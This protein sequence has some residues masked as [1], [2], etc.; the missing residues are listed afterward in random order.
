MTLQINLERVKNDLYTV[1]R[2]GYN[3]DDQG[4]YRQG[5]SDE[6]IKARAWF[7]KKLADLEL[8]NYMDGAGNVIG[9]LGRDDQKALL[10]GS[11]LDSVPAGGMF[12]GVLGAI[13]GLECIRILQENQVP[14]KHALEVIGTSEEEGRFGG[15]LG[16]Q[17]LTGN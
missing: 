2:Y 17:A 5:F 6:D 15:M 1:G 4:V 13:A 12:D 8:K 11:H 10:I 7:Q 16:A 14:L 3:P 9:R